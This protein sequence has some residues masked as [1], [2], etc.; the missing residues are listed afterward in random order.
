VNYSETKYE[1]ILSTLSDN[2][3]E[4]EMFQKEA[5]NVHINLYFTIVVDCQFDVK[6]KVRVVTELNQ[7]SLVKAYFSSQQT[8]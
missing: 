5:N 7:S 4:S 6:V 2:L 8:I 1:F 3:T